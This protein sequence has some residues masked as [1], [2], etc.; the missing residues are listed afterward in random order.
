MGASNP[1]PHGQI[2][3]GTALPR[4]GCPRG[5]PPSAAHLAT[6][7]RRLLLDYVDQEQAGPRVVVENDDWLVVVPFW[8]AWPFETLIIAKR[9]TARLAGPRRSGARRARRRP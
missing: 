4:P 9:P 3:A 5:A 7:G 1:H 6:T 2:W 8:A